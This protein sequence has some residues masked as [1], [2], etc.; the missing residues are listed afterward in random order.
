MLQVDG[1]YIILLVCLLLQ[2]LGGRAGLTG[3]VSSG[4]PAA[5]CVQHCSGGRQGALCP[6]NRRLEAAHA[7][8]FLRAAIVLSRP[9]QWRRLNR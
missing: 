7:R 8:L 6:L 5:A 9:L 3:T 2:I 1:I 4:Q